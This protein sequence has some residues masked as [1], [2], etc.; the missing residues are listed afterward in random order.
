V[1]DQRLS[2]CHVTPSSSP[3]PLQADILIWKTA[4]CS[5]HPCTLKRP[6]YRQPPQLD[7]EDR[8]QLPNAYNQ[9]S[10]HRLFRRGKDKLAR[11]GACILQWERFDLKRQ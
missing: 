10:R 8:A 9:T 6:D 5:L 4:A 11:P 2:Q 7:S 3:S 1:F